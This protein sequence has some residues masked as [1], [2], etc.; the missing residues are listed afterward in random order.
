MPLSR[1]QSCPDTRTFLKPTPGTRA[2]RSD[3]EKA[4]VGISPR[5]FDRK[6]V[7]VWIPAPTQEDTCRPTPMDTTFA[8]K[9]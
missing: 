2:H 6:V 4:I 1:V 7:S 9:G 3:R 8:Y 5:L